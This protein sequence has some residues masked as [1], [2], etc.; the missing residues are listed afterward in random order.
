V[1]SHALPRIGVSACLFHE[2]RAR[3]VFNG[4]PLSYLENSMGRWIAS[5][6]ALVYMIPPLVPDAAAT[7]EAYADDLDG[8]VLQGGVDVSPRTYDE[9]P[10]RPEWAGDAVRDAYEIELVRAFY[11]RGKP[12]LGVCRGHQILNVAFGGTLHQ[13]I[14]TLV[15]GAHVHRDATV[16]ERL[17][18]E[19]DV[20]P[21]SEL[22]RTLGVAGRAKVNS[23]H[24][25]SI[26]RLA[27]GFE[28]DAYSAEDGVIEAAHLPGG[29]F[30][31]GVQWHPEFT[32]PHDPS[33]LDNTPLL[34]AFLDAA[35]RLYATRAET[36]RP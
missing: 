19:I 30:V 18:H 36:L 17:A 22:A 31:R 21:G 23:V 6:G 4:R 5:G 27:P 14:V 12:V 11:A 34:R 2:D 28:V 24:H 33:Y 10:L 29:S 15:P 9:E 35:R 13:D 7:A 25:Q 26:N 16:Y 3:P 1:A 32:D 20:A 8:L